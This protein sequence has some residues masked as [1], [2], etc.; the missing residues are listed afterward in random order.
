MKCPHGLVTARTF[1]WHARHLLILCLLFCF[2]MNTHAAELCIHMYDDTELTIDLSDVTSISYQE[3]GVVFQINMTDGS[4][5]SLNIVDIRKL[6]FGSLTGITESEIEL[7]STFHRLRNY[8]NPFNCSTTLEYELPRAGNVEAAIYD[9]RGRK[10][11][12]LFNDH[13]Q[14]GI[15]HLHWDGTSEDGTNIASGLYICK[16]SFGTK[17]LVTHLMLVK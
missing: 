17:Q 10:I 16:V 15:H 7:I 1:H 3:S 5:Q 4:A 12:S 8:P 13:Q 2:T 11:S 6:T 14:A 9:I